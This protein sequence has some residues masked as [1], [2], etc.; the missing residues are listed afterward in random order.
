MAPTFG[1]RA[2]WP[3]TIWPP[4][5]S[6]YHHSCQGQYCWGTTIRFGPP[7]DCKQWIVKVNRAPFIKMNSFF[8]H[9]C[10]MLATPQSYYYYHRGALLSA[11]VT[12]PRLDRV[13]H[14]RRQIALTIQPGGGNRDAFIQDLVFPSS[15]GMGKMCVQ[16]KSLPETRC[17]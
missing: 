13:L 17:F 15:N 16:T 10:R 7:K 3:L 6:Q 9:R 5:D 1:R 2:V 4:F 14:H 11:S 8:T 12:F